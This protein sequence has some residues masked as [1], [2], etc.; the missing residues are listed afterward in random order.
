MCPECCAKVK[1][2]GDNS[3]TPVRDTGNVTMRKKTVDEPSACTAVRPVTAKVKCA[4]SSRVENTANSNQELRELTS[5]L[6]L[7]TDEITQLKGKLQDATDSLISCHSRLDQYHNT[8]QAAEARITNLELE[9]AEYKKLLN[10]VNS[11]IR[12]LAQ[13]QLSNEVEVTGVPECPAENLHHIVSLAA[14]RV[15]VNLQ[16]GDIDWITRVGPR[17]GQSSDT[18]AKPPLPRPIVV[19]LTRRATRDQLLRQFRSRRNIL[20]SQLEV[21]GS[22]MTVYMNERLTKENRLLFREAR[23]WKKDKNFE[24]CWYYNGTIYIRQQQGKPAFVIRSLDDLQGIP[25]QGPN[26]KNTAT[27]QLSRAAVP[28]PVSAPRVDY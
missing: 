28:S 13:A 7:L 3:S 4:G 21:A 18:A 12:S 25:T 26:N 14:N 6:R 8:M 19:R 11:E 16:D 9:N 24:G 17:R 1:R 20:S 22:A 10:H 15:G 2:S 27:D 5:Q 23:K